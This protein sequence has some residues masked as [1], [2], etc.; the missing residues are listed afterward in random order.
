L[1]S[2]LGL[3]GAGFTFGAAGLTVLMAGDGLAG[4]VVDR[5]ATDI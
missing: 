2:N 3:G 1:G 5:P 4:A